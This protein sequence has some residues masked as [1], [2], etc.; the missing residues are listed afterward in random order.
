[1]KAHVEPVGSGGELVI[2]PLRDQHRVVVRGGRPHEARFR[3]VHEVAPIVQEDEGA[4][5]LVDL[6]RVAVERYLPHGAAP[7][8][9]ADSERVGADIHHAGAIGGRSG[10]GRGRGRLRGGGRDVRRRRDAGGPPGLGAGGRAPAARP[11]R[12]RQV[13]RR[14]RVANGGGRLAPGARAEVFLP[15]LPQQEAHHRETDE[16]DG[17]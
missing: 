7:R 1:M 9:D 15:R 5:R 11:A 8:I 4:V 13:P 14:R 2:V 16:Q 3:D 12:V 17:T 10:R 6:D